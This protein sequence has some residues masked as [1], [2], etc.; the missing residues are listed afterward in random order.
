MAESLV[1]V[2]S[3]AKART[4]GR[5]LGKGYTVVASV[6]HVRDLPKNDLG[7]DVENGFEPIYEA[8]PAKRKV[9]AEIQ[10][11]ARLA[12]RVLLATDPDREGEAIGW[13]LAELL[14]G[15]DKPVERVLFHEIT[16]RAVQEAITHPRPLDQHLVDSQQARRVLDR[17]MG[18]KLSPLL[19]DK[20]KRGLSA[21]RVQSV[22]LK[23]ICDREGEIEAFVP[24][25]YWHL[26]ARLAGAQPPAFVA[27]LALRDG[28][29]FSVHD[30]ET[31]AAV[32]AEVE[33]ARFL[34][35]KVA[36]R[37]RQQ[38]SAPPFVTAK[39]QQAAYKRHH[40]PV[41]RT[42]Q[43]A[44]KLYEGVDLGGGER[45]GLITYMRT[46]SMRVAAEALAA[47]RDLI[48][49]QYGPGVLPEKPNFF[50][51]RSEAQDAH[52]AIRPTDPARTP[53][54]MAR[55]LSAD[56][57]KLYTLI[58]QRFVASQ[59]N[60]AQFDVTDVLV[61]AGRYG[62][63][64]KGEVEVEAGFLR[65]YREDEEE[66][67][68]D[69]P[70]VEQEAEEATSKRLPPL[71]E[72]DTLALE[73]FL[74][75]QKF[76]QPPP[77]FTESTL[78]KAL[79]ENG[80]GRPSTY[81]QIIATLSDRSYV[82]RQKGTFFPSELGKLVSRLLQGSFGDLINESYTARM[83]EELDAIA[84]GKLD[85]RAALAGFW[86]TFTSD[87]ERAKAEMTS[88]KRQGVATKEV[89]PTCGAPMLLR[90]G[91]Y[92]EYLACSNYPTCKTTREP[93]APGVTDEAPACPDCNAPM[94]LKR[95]RF[96]Q[97]WACSRY[98]ECKGIRKLITGKTSPNTPTGV[99]CPECGEG[100]IVEKRSRKGR[101]F[102]G[103]NRYPKC[104]FTLPAKPVPQPCP[105]CGAPFVMEKTTV[106]RG[107]EWVC[108]K[109]GCGF[110]G[111]AG[112]GAPTTG[113]LAPATVEV[114]PPKPPKV[115]EAKP[116]A[117]AVKP[118]AKAAKIKT[119]QAKAPAR[120]AKPAKATKPAPRTAKPASRV[121]KPA[122]RAAKPAVRAK[123]GTAKRGK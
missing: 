19:W 23:M 38:K 123:R 62:F 8:L 113:E 32:K 54:S 105:A 99:R 67:A 1:I 51:N 116:A 12:D 43:L 20:V 84:E 109:E 76:T 56:E 42:M 86:R 78:V 45:V 74:S 68:G 73:E 118:P 83:E 44:Q 106:R 22:A 53:E 5:Y 58:W 15:L 36:K 60:P 121:A 114:Q 21:G 111:P 31:A 79:E 103:C 11:A 71:T 55:Y 24:E 7:I 29:K 69:K 66:S 63:K 85:W 81:A 48:A 87:L 65:V 64:A 72:G 41:R 94:V 52:E 13:H 3:P 117:R 122:S 28:K 98:P 91:R 93:G 10:A 17:L 59:M 100:E 18:Y 96:G 110:R 34:V 115:R 57:L 25:E 107:V 14:A 80:I 82:D 77:R 4:L 47:V 97:F 75:L 70:A 33:G 95:S 102:W 27:R 50:K 9:I 2:E 119:Q 6:G 39:L 49:A 89:C 108:A 30:G 26:D 35:A 112:E 16:K 92:G 88:V 40:Y 46:D 120:A 90:F 61:E 104:S 101:S 37:R